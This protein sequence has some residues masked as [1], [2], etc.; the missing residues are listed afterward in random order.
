M[1]LRPLL[2][3]FHTVGAVGITGGLAAYMIVLA[4]V[5]ETATFSEYLTIRTS[6]RQISNLLIVPAM[7]IVLFS[8]LMVM[9]VHYPFHNALWAWIKAISGILIFEETLRSIDAASEKAVIGVSKVLSQELDPAELSQYVDDMWLSWWVILALCA[10]NIVLGVWRPR[11]S[12]RRKTRQRAQ[13]IE[14]E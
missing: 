12:G 4:S 14:S 8:G 11:F 2:K 6:L 1:R 5:P 10:L 3:F 13:V 7:A 9:A